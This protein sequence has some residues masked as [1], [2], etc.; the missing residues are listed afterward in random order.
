MQRPDTD[1]D[2]KDMYGTDL[3]IILDDFEVNLRGI[4]ILEQCQYHYDEE[5]FKMAKKILLRFF[6][7]ESDDDPL[8]QYLE[9]LEC[10]NIRFGPP[11][12]SR[13]PSTL[14]VSE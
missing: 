11:D 13:L 5:V 3:A 10:Q 4:D 9:S 8:V 1:K 12:F 2:V 14:E 6:E 7:P